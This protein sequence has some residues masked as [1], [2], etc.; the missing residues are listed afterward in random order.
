MNDNKSTS[1]LSVKTLPLAILFFLV[2][3]SVSYGQSDRD[4]NL[5]DMP[6]QSENS[7]NYESPESASDYRND[8]Y[9]KSNSNKETKTTSQS[10]PTVRKENPIY[11]QGS[12]KE[13]RKE[14]TSTLSFNLFL[15]VVDKFKED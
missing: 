13:I 4:R 15:Y 14:S 10:T 1:F 3:G 5:P 8:A 7:T 6:R 2:F 11:K 12:D 9:T